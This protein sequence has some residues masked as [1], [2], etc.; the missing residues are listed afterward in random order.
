MLVL[1]LHALLFFSFMALL[2]GQM[3]MFPN[4]VNNSIDGKSFAQVGNATQF[5]LPSIQLD[6]YMPFSKCLNFFFI[7]NLSTLSLEP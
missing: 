4:K 3:L 1:L 7:K 6:V 5:P 2:P